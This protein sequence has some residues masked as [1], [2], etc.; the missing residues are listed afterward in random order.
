M[1]TSGRL[2]Q[3]IM[4][5]EKRDLSSFSSMTL[6]ALFILTTLQLLFQV[7][8]FLFL[9]VDHKL[10]FPVFSLSSTKVLNS[11]LPV[12]LCWHKSYLISVD[13]TTLVTRLYI[14]GILILGS[15]RPVNAK[16]KQRVK[17]LA[18]KIP[19]V[20][21][22]AFLLVIIN[23]VFMFYTRKFDLFEHGILFFVFHII[24]NIPLF[25]Q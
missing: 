2:L 21:D 18:N 16:F 13:M 19:F 17:D 23:C 4:N 7:L 11:F 22:L 6:T 14:I 8:S 3:I 10:T 9:I 5:R 24:G 25:A 20:V 12:S 1:S 15:T